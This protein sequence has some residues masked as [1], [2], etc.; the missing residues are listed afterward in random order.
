MVLGLLAG[1]GFEEVAGEGLVGVEANAGVL[2]IDDDGIEVF[3]LLVRGTLVGIVRAVEAGDVEA[4]GWVGFGGEAGGVLLAE[5][6][7]LG[8][9]ERREVRGRN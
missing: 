9:E 2:E 5:D 7:V 8:G 1:G 6:A 4:G 3:E